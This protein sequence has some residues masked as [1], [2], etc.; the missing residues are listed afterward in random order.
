MCGCG[1]GCGRRHEHHGYRGRR[2][3]TREERGKDLEEYADELKKELA[4]VE[5]QIKELKR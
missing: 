2:F 3:F 4:A 1:C 5:E